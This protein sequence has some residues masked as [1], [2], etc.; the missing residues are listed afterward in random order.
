MFLDSTPYKLTPAQL[1]LVRQPLETRIFLEG[2]AG[3]GKTTAGVERLLYLMAQGVPAS[4][5]LVLVPQ[6]TLG[7]PYQVALRYPGVVAGGMV[8]VQTMGGVAQRMVDLFWPMIAPAAGFE[9][10]DRP[11]VFLTLET[12]QYYMAHL[13]MPLLQEG[14]FESAKVERNRIFSQILDNLNKAALV[15][16]PYQETGHRLA[17][18][19]IGEPGQLRIYEDVQECMNLFRQYCLANNL[20]DYSLQIEV[21]RDHLWPLENCRSYLQETYRHLIVDNLEEDT[22][23]TSDILS[24]WLPNLASCLII[25]DW[26]GGFRR[27]LGADPGAASSLKAA[28]NLTINFTDGLVMSEPV[29]NLAESLNQIFE[30][31]NQSGKIGGR[32]TKTTRRLQDPLVI[33]QH[34]FYPEMLD[35]IASQIARLVHEDGLPPSEI[36]VLAPYLSDSLRFLLLTRLEDQKVPVRSHRPSRAL[37]EESVTRCLLT[38]ANLAYPEWR[39]PPSK[40]DVAFAMMQSIEGM[41]LVRAQLLTE[42]VYRIQQG[43]PTLTSFDPIVAATRARITYQLGERYEQLRLWLAQQREPPEAFDHFLNRLFGEVLSQ[44]GFGF[45]N[46]QAA[47]EITAN[48]IESIQKFRWVTQT[49]LADEGVPL[50]QEYCRMVQEGVIAAQYVRSWEFQSEQSV[51]VA[52]AFTFLMS[53]RPVRVQ[54]WLDIGSRGWSERLNQPLTQPYVLTR[55]WQRGRPWTDYDE[56]AVGRELMI[57]LVLG[58]LQRCRERIYL[59]LSELGEQGYETRGPLLQALQK[60]LLAGQG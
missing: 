34:H 26:N 30:P 54:F 18:A 21:F 40:S 43:I 45:V 4:Q 46:N 48:L 6:R 41:D 24:S 38:L 47:G 39:I 51:L 44:P 20:L 60:V 11:P 50:G 14:Y 56:V 31:S 58:L 7:E 25:Y 32:K 8:S 16:F 13:V 27:F 17:E 19:W 15:G 55:N 52:P 22:P 23:F 1:R 9:R 37:R 10:P 33:Q 28:C 36:V 12:A 57:T 29:A 42:I 3:T 59:G 5:I 53:N 35:W 2:P 49:T